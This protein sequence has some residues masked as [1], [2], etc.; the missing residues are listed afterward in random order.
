MAIRFTSAVRI[1]VVYRDGQGAAA[2]GGYMAPYYAI[3]IHDRTS[4]ERR[5]YRVDADR[6]A[7][8]PMHRSYGRAPAADSSEAYTL[9]AADIVRCWLKCNAY[10][11]SRTL[12][13]E[14][15]RPLL[16]VLCD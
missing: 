16:S 13:T 15:G 11:V 4:G 3:R 12:T 2:P 14:T 8:A 5:S 9:I 10:G 7:A 1:F 6:S